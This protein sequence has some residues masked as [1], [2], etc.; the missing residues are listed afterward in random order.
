[1]KRP[2]LVFALLAC[3]GLP[4]GCKKATIESYRVPKEQVAQ[5]TPS[6][7]AHGQPG[8]APTTP[9]ASTPAAGGTMASTPVAT[10][11]GASLEWAAPAQWEAGPSSAMRRGSYVVRGEGDAKADMAITAFPG[12]VGGELANLNRW[13]GQINLPPIT[14]G[15]FEQNVQR[16]ERNGLKMVVVDIAGTGSGA[17]RILG[18]MVPNGSSTWFFKMQGPDALVAKEK[19]AFMKLLDSVKV[20]ASAK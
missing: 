7:H 19:P 10:A 18:A 5:A 15:E 20:A 1:M 12:N 14:Q 16:I 11:G 6:P 17:Q 8:T 2:C 13:R 3:L 9:P 4:A